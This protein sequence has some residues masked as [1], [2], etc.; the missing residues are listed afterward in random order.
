MV[1]V[2]L[3]LD[4]RYRHKNGTFPLKLAI[5]RKHTFY[6][7][8]G[9]DVRPED[10]DEAAQ[11]IKNVPNY[12]ILT[13]L[14]RQRCSEAESRILQL[15]A[16]GKLRSFTDKALIAYLQKEDENELPHLFKESYD[17]FLSLKT[18][19]STRRIYE[20]TAALIR[21]FT[22][23]FDSLTFEEMN[24]RWLT[25]FKVFLMKYCKSKNGESIHFRNIRAVFN[26]AI[27]QETI[28]CYPF[29]NFQL[30][31][32]ETDKRSM[33][34]KQMQSF[35]DLDCE[36]W[37]Q[38]YKDA[39]LLTFYLIGINVADLSQ[40]DAPTDGRLQY[41]RFKTHKLYNIKVEPEAQ[42][43]LDT[44][45]GQSH[46]LSWFDSVSDYKH[47]ANKCNYWLGELGKKIGIDNL[48][49]YWAR[50]T[51][52]TFAY[53]LD[54]PDDTISRALGHSQTTGAH[55]TKVYIRTDSKKVDAA[56]RAVIDYVLGKKKNAQN[57]IP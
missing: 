3:R 34:L 48:T 42:A 1:K 41:L 10:W 4:T 52:A 20:R 14:A 54:I 44:Y 50:H 8:V 37:Q 49:L 21:E 25:D 35:I 57:V 45:K 7:P 39:F 12:K 53:D 23:H 11:R 28:T 33:S 55:V 43:I 9:I 38:R 6:V 32:E 51:W 2:S 17:L 27:K 47:F 24:V 19:A 30:E 56:N 29:R 22:P 40:L 31:Y 36:P 18:N 5:A 46:L 13:A 16:S 26:F 15:Q